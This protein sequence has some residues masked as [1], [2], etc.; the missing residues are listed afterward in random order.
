MAVAWSP[1]VDLTSNHWAIIP[2]P[3]VVLDQGQP[4][5]HQHSLLPLLGSW[6]VVGLYPLTWAPPCPFGEQA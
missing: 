2:C 4:H 3:V 1:C 5:T 6:C